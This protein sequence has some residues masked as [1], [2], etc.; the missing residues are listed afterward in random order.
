M[1][2]AAVREAIK[3]AEEFLRRAKAVKYFSTG[4]YE[5][6]KSDPKATGALRRQSLELTRVLAEMRRP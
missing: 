3:Q 4:G 1:K 5:Y 6:L 2:S